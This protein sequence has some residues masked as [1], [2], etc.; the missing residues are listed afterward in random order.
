[1]LTLLFFFFQPGDYMQKDVDV[2]EMLQ[3]QN[4][5]HE[6]I[7]EFSLR[8]AIEAAKKLRRLQEE[9]NPGGEDYWPWV[10]LCYLSVV[11]HP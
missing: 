9:R 5:S 10:F 4:K 7:I 1:M 2:L 8:G 6:E 3:L 11:L